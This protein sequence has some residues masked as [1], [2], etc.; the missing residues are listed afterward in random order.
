[1]PILLCIWF[2]AVCGLRMLC[3]LPFLRSLEDMLLFFYD[4]RISC[5]VWLFMLLFVFTFDDFC[6]WVLFPFIAPVHIAVPFLAVQP[7]L[8]LV[9]AYLILFVCSG[10]PG[11]TRFVC[12]TLLPSTA[13]PTISFVG[14]AFRFT[15]L[16]Y[17]S[18]SFC[19][20]LTAAFSMLTFFCW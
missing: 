4:I 5:F 12:C 15:L 6:V 18:L 14:T 8:V 7:F 9:D 1:M 10:S 17:L 3:C 13:Y 19:A 2:T 16:H 20:P 11:R